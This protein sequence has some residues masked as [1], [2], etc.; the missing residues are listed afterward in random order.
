MLYSK[1]KNFCFTQTEQRSKER[2]IAIMAA[3][4]P[5]PISFKKPTSILADYLKS[6]SPA[7][8]THHCWFIQKITDIPPF[9]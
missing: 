9:L 3:R 8:Y 6:V 5:A 2:R 1:G 4:N 7:P